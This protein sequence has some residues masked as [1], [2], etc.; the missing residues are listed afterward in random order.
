MKKL[1]EKLKKKLSKPTIDNVFS[2]QIRIEACH[3]SSYKICTCQIAALQLSNSNI[4]QFDQ[5]SISSQ[6]K[7]KNVVQIS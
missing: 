5:K 7:V 1:C 4:K 6:M 3:K 2:W